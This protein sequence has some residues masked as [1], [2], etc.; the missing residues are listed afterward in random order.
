[1]STNQKHWSDKHTD[2][3]DDIEEE[4]KNRKKVAA[5]FYESGGMG[6]NAWA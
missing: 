1:M 6:N 2:D 5:R 3:I 4:K